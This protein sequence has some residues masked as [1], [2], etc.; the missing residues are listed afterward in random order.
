MMVKC[1]REAMAAFELGG[2]EPEAA[3]RSMIECVDRELTE[4][5]CEPAAKPLN[6][7]M[8]GG[9][10]AGGVVL[11]GGGIYLPTRD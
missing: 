8:I 3:L 9:L 2:A 10:V 4:Y 7:W 1:I 5:G 11:V 6:P